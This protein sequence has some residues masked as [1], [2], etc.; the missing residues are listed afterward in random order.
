[1]NYAELIQNNGGF[2]L[3][4][5]DEI[6]AKGYMVSLEGFERVIRNYKEYPPDDLNY[7]CKNF[8][9]SLTDTV[10]SRWFGAWVNGDD[11]YLDASIN[12][13]F[14]DTALEFARQNKQLAIWDVVNG[15]SID[16]N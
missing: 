1:M 2:S 16:V 8:R 3:N 6:P 10:E 5:R 12:V 11:L 14:L 4:H 9:L 13:Q 7:L 15:V